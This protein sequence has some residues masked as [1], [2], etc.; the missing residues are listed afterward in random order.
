M[1]NEAPFDLILLGGGHAHCA[2]LTDWIANGVPAQRAALVSPAPHLRYSGMVPGWIAGQY[3][4]DAGLV[5]VRALALQAGI[6]F[7]E[8]RCIAIDPVANA[9]MTEASGVLRFANCSIDTGGVGKA[10]KLLGDDARLIDVRPID[11]LVE[12]LEAAGSPEN[13]TVIGGGA[14]GVELAFALNNRPSDEPQAIALITGKAGLLPDFARGPR[15]MV[16]RELEMQEIAV[17]ESDAVLTDGTL[18]MGDDPQTSADDPLKSAEIL[19]ASLGSGAPDWP[20]SGGLEVDENGFIA[21]DKFQRSISHSHIFAVGDVASRQDIH[22]PRSGV[23][24]VHAGPLLAANLRLVLSGEEPRR[25]YRPRKFSLYILSTANEEA[26]AVYGPVATK[27][28]WAADLKAWI[29]KR[30]LASY[31]KLTQDM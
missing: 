1:K 21:V 2:V 5:D 24:A 16:R 25:S 8:D 9:V 23:H 17:F 28:E 15:E 29:D 22:V 26:I 3:P 18:Q 12:R 27:A 10:A 4:A 6:T 31:A 30:W 11:G 14:G 13:V 20:A 7:I 19:V